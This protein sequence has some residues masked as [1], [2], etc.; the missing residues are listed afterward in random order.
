MGCVGRWVARGATRAQARSSARSSPWACSGAV[1]P[2][3]QDGLSAADIG[4]NQRIRTYVTVYRVV[5]PTV[6]PDQTPVTVQLE[7]VDALELEYPDGAHD[8]EALIVDPDSGDLLIVSKED[9]GEG[10]VFRAAAPHSVASRIPLEVVTTLSFGSDALPGGEKV[11]GGDAS[12]DGSAILLRTGTS[13]FWWQRPES[14]P[15]WG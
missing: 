3:L 14:G 12:P 2:S 6:A 15:L 8:A 10:V 1:C 7:E 5:E 11:T 9:D 13:A 4:D